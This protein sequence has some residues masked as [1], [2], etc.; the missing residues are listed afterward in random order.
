MTDVPCMPRA[1]TGTHRSLGL[2]LRW[3]W[4]FWA[5]LFLLLH[6]P[7]VLAERA[8]KV[9]E[10]ETQLV[11]GAYQMNAQINY[12]FSD[13]ALEALDNGVPLTLDVHLRVRESDSWIWSESL[14]DRHLRFR[15]RYLPLS[16]RYRVRQLPGGLDE[17]YVTRDAAIAALGEIRNLQLLDQDRLDPLQQYELQLRVSLDIEELPLPLRP[18]A[19]LYPAWKHSSKWSRWPLT[20]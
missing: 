16:G 18:F 17:T 1:L 12:R 11:Q 19:Y 13:A 14:I 3:S 20:P 7:E 9:V 2:P 5:F 6:A 15:I 10:A 4:L 8:F